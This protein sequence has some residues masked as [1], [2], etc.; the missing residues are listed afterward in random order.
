MDKSFWHDMRTQVTAGVIVGIVLSQAPV[1]FAPETFELTPP[2]CR[3]L[4]ALRHRVDART[5]LHDLHERVA[6]DG[7]HIDRQT[8]KAHLQHDMEA[9]EHAGIVHIERAPGGYGDYYK[10]TTPEG[11]D[12]VLSKQRELQAEAGKGLTPREQGPRYR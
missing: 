5:T 3:A 2:R 1:R 6:D 12:W 11:R 9:A 10:L 4:L 8:T 7:T